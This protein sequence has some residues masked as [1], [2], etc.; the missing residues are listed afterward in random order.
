MRVPVPDGSVT[1]LVCVLGARPTKEEI[2]AAFA[3][4]RRAGRSPGKLVYTEDPIVSSDIVGSPASCTFDALA[5]MADRATWSRSS[6]GTT[7]SGA[8]RTGWSTWPTLVASK[9]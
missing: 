8:T 2:N 7:T 4:A 3:A 6:A 1:D 5:T 9:L